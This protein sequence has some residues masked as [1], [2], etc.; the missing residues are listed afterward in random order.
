MK[1]AKELQAELTSLLGEQ[2]QLREDKN[3]LEQLLRVV[4]ATVYQLEA[5]L[6]L[7]KIKEVEEAYLKTLEPDFEN[8]EFLLLLKSLEAT[9][10]YSKLRDFQ[11][12]GLVKL[13]HRYLIETNPSYSGSIGFINADDA[14]LG[15]TLTTIAFLQTLEFLE[16]SALT[17]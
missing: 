11:K 2:A 10:S 13:L 6:K 12:E 15:K 7:A 16:D 1:T 5:E 14:G 8:P 17:S 9:P 4:S 3:E